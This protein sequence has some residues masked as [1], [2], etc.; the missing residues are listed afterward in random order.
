METKESYD[1]RKANLFNAEML[2][3]DKI[4]CMHGGWLDA[5]E[6]SKDYAQ[7]LVKTK[8]ACVIG[9]NLIYILA[10]DDKENSIIEYFNIK[11]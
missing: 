8:D 2:T 11:V 9:D 10:D 7:H 6:Y 3:E 5:N 1:N 4:S